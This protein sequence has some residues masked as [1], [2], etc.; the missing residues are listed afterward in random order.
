M[1]VAAALTRVSE[2]MPMVV[3]GTVH[4]HPR[5]S[6]KRITL[7]SAAPVERDK[8]IAPLQTGDWRISSVVAMR[9]GVDL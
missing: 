5:R 1:S 2:A 9:A 7:D 3:I 4:R 8:R 6:T